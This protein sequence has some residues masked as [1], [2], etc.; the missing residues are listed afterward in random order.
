[1]LETNAL[2][3]LFPCQELALKNVREICRGLHVSALPRLR[4]R[5][6]SL[7]GGHMFVPE[8]ADKT[9][10]WIRDQA[11]III[12]VDLAAVGSQLAGDT[13]YRSQFETCTSRGTLS[14]ETRNR[15]EAALFNT[16]YIDAPPEQRCKYG[17]LNV[18]NDPQ[19]IRR[20][21]SYGTS[22]LLLKDVRL[23]TTFSA[24]DSGG[25]NIEDLAT[26][27]Y[28]AHVL[29]KYGDEELRAAVEV[30]TRRSF[31]RDSQVLQK[32]KEAQIHGPVKLADHVELIMAHPSLHGP[33][34]RDMLRQLSAVCNAQVVWIEDG[35]IRTDP[36]DDGIAVST[37]SE[38][39]DA[40]SSVSPAGSPGHDAG[41][42]VARAIEASRILAEEEKKYADSLAALEAS[43]LEQALELSKSVTETYKE[44]RIAATCTN[45]CGRNP[46]EGYTTCCR[47]CG[48]TGGDEHG[49]ICQE[50]AQ[51]ARAIQASKEMFCASGCGRHAVVGQLICERCKDE[52]EK[53]ERA[54]L[55]SKE[56][57]QAACTKVCGCAALPGHAVCLRCQEEQNEYEELEKAIQASKEAEQ[58]MCANGCSLP[59]LH[60][61][62]VCARCR[63]EEELIGAIRASSED[64][65]A[66]GASTDGNIPL[67]RDDSEALNTE[68]IQLLEED[69]VQVHV[70]E[71]AAQGE[72]SSVAYAADC[73]GAISPRGEDGMKCAKADPAS[74]NYDHDGVSYVQDAVEAVENETQ[75]LARD[76]GEVSA[77]ETQEADDSG[78]EMVH[79]LKATMGEDTRRCQI[80]Y[81]INAGVGVMLAAISDAVR[82]VH[83]LQS[84]DT[85]V[86]HY[87]DHTDGEM[88]ALVETTVQDFLRSQQGLC[89]RVFA[90]VAA[91]ASLD[92]NA[93][94]DPEARNGGEVDKMVATPGANS[95]FIGDGDMIED[96]LT[97]WYDNQT[98]E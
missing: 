96:P 77:M 78:M 54:I 88:L 15:W 55:A 68:A 63:E 60:G 70:A 85:L 33:E 47:T 3:D 65:L 19:G 28:Y 52:Q 46:A 14:H 32:Y 66:C 11:P 25:I 31:G 91:T 45:G 50:Q 24:R 59:I 6:R 22:Y 80:A 86:L 53:L 39:P 90:K 34:H 36:V 27:D 79:V 16:A 4:E 67:S 13:H 72:A 56:T 76:D 29:E 48:E 18:T 89:L 17:V 37:H 62:V 38:S 97:A 61:C 2:E 21:S 1:M 9:L 74:D 10:A 69:Y 7:G 64:I 40:V 81:S 42:D 92:K 73:A 83:V 43:E 82:C 12:H 20:C 87:L 95:F 44:T 58:A 23:R 94:S 75:V 41:D 51:I 30:G 35:R 26:V 5:M 98:F 57:H 93:H 8:D 71:I 84:A 49:P